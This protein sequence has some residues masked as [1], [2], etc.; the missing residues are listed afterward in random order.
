[1]TDERLQIL[2]MVSDGVITAADA[3]K[4]LAALDSSAPPKSTMAEDVTTQPPTDTPDMRVFRRYW[5]YPFFVGIVLLGIAGL[6]VTNTS[7][8]PLLI[9]GWSAFAT[10]GLLTLAGWLSQWSPWVHV[11]IREHDGDRISFSLPLPL[12]LIGLLTRLVQPVVR[13]FAGAETGDNLDMVASFLIMMEDLPG[14]EPIAIDVNDEDGDHIQ[15][16]VG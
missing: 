5:D 9:C 2:Q 8:T 3:E 10:A 6:C 1:M 15:V 11:R 12:R 14:D 7:S 13:R 4:L 16:Y